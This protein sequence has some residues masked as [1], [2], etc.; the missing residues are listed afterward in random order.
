MNFFY[1]RERITLEDGKLRR[2]S[3]SGFLLGEK[4]PRDI[5]HPLLGEVLARKNKKINKKIIKVLQEAEVTSLPAK[6]EDIEGYYLAQDV[7]DPGT[8]EV[9]AASNEALTQ[10]KLNQLIQKKV[11][12]F[13]LLFIRWGQCQ[14]FPAGYLDYR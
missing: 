7:I 10:D 6:N 3:Q 9:L 12:H 1:D 8:G 13:D 14:L 4:V 5:V 2:G 11:A